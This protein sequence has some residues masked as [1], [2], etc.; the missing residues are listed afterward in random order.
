MSCTGIVNCV[1]LFGIRLFVEKLPSHPEYAKAAPGDKATNKKVY[2][3]F[4]KTHWYLST[5]KKD[6]Q[7]QTKSITVKGVNLR[8]WLI[9]LRIASWCNIDNL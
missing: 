5:L 4:N 3:T 9:V 7:R 6:R 8:V 1:S 2:N